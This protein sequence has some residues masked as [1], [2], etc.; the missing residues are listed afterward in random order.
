[1]NIEVHTNQHYWSTIEL[2][3]TPVYSSVLKRD[4]YLLILGYHHFENNEKQTGRTSLD[5]DRL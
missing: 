1:M 2:Y 4:R 3:H 5:Y